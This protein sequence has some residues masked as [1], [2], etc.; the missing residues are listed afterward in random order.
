MLVTGDAQAGIAGSA[1]PLPLI[2]KVTDDLDRPVPGQG[3]DFT[4]TS[5]GGGVSLASVE[6]GSDGRASVTWTLGASAGAQAVQ[7]KV[8]GAG[9]PDDLTFDFS[10]TAVAGSGSLI[11]AVSGDDQSAPVNSSLPDSLVVRVSDGNGNPVSGISITWSVQG[12][13]SISPET[14]VTDD[15]GRAAAQ[16]VLGP[17]AGQQTAQAAGDGLAGSPV[18]F[19][20]TA[21]ASNPTALTLVSGDAQGAPAGFDSRGISWSS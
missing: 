21:V 9:V 7:A 12:G 11:A 2:V 1:L 14:V 20:Q 8:V 18:T 19:V 17:A 13:G 4:V 3:V 10:A 15:G 5:G 16:R 6:T